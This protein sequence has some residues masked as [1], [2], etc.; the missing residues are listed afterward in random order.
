[1]LR[2][3]LEWLIVF[4]PLVTL[5]YQENYFFHFPFTSRGAVLGETLVGLPDGASA[6]QGNPA[7][8]IYKKE[9]EIV[10]SYVSLPEGIKHG[11]I[12]YTHGER[13]WGGF[14][15][16]LNYLRGRDVITTE[17]NPTGTG[18]YTVQETLLGVNYS[19]RLKDF[20]L[21]L[22]LKTTLQIYPHP[23]A[24]SKRSTIATGRMF[25]IGILWKKTLTL[26]L[27]LGITLTN[28]GELQEFI[29]GKQELSPKFI[30]GVGVNVF[31]NFW[32]ASAISY[33]KPKLKMSF[34]L[35]YSLWK[36]LILRAGYR[37]GPEIG[38]ISGGLGIVIFKHPLLKKGVLDYSFII[39]TPF[40][41][42]H[43]FSLRIEL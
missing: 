34:G 25:D 39:Y 19:Y 5:S 26:P 21:G 13:N 29:E 16:G 7:G 1:M 37:F 35:E 32:I 40:S 41:P 24:P 17:D 28:L 4:F 31:R 15:F 11:F 10:F 42:L 27:W 14:G 3:K 33:L 30:L 38:K 20:L 43:A 12:G 8:S 23:E 18:F 9:P 2:R 6:L 36:R 22:N